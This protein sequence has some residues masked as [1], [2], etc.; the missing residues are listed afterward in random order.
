MQTEVALST[1]EAEYIAL[2]TA[3]REVIWLMDL[4]SELKA[5]ISPRILAIPTVYCK[6]FEDNSGAYEL[7]TA[8]KMRPRTKHINAKYHHFRSH[9]DRKLI[10][11]EQVTSANQLADFFTKQCAL[12]LYQSFRKQIMGWDVSTV[13]T[14]T[15]E[16]V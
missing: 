4:C 6:A 11:I 3:L 12:E 8:P 2:S 5:K 16:G 7:A 13:S 15:D 1:T 10:Q 9:V 14:L